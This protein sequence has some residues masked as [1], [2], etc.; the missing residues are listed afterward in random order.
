MVRLLLQRSACGYGYRP[1]YVN[2][3]GTMFVT[4]VERDKDE[5]N[6][7]LALGLG[8]GFGIPIFICIAVF[9]VYCCK[10]I[11]KER[12]FT[13]EIDEKTK[14]IQIMPPL[15]RWETFINEGSYIRR[16]AQLLE[17]EQ[18]IPSEIESYFKEFF[19]DVWAQVEEEGNNFITKTAL[20]ITTLFRE[21]AKLEKKDVVVVI[22]SWKERLID[23]SGGEFAYMIFDVVMKNAKT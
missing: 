16:I 20:L 23:K 14:Q 7:S 11:V 17:S 3:N 10:S 21:Q 2:I 13:N 22:E 5:M 19:P 12:K 1:D 9:I 8:L 4:C 15:R 6:A 18:Y